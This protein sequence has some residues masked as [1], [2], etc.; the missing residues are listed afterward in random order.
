MELTAR[1]SPIVKMVELIMPQDANN[2]GT[3]FG[4]KLLE[5]IDKCAAITAFR[6][7]GQQVVTASFESIDFIEPIQIAEVIELTGKIIYTGRTSLVIQVDVHHQKGNGPLSHATCGYT[8]FVSVDS[9]GKP[10]PVPP[11]TVT[12]IEEK[13]L[14]DRGK[15]I[16]D[17][18]IE[19]S[20]NA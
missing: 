12:T 20:R 7:C 19:R 13:E 3:L 5:F 10:I 15:K 8:V 9:K 11:L 16:K 4:G 17:K 1:P 18:A 2:F 6:F 14:W